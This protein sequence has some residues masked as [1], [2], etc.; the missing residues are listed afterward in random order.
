MPSFSRHRGLATKKKKRRGRLVQPLMDIE[1][2]EVS[3]QRMKKRCAELDTENMQLKAAKA[4]QEAKLAQK[5]REI[6]VILK[7]AIAEGDPSGNRSALMHEKMLVSSL[8][9]KCKQLYKDLRLKKAELDHIKSQLKFSQLHELQV[10]T[11]SCS[12]WF[13]CWL[14]TLLC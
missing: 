12:I 1:E 5:D 6:E 2:F 9:S 4:R 14:L 3:L 13:M 7:K 8:Q 10:N 11:F